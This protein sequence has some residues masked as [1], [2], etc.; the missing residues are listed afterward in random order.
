MILYEIL[1]NFRYRVRS[2]T[3][4]NWRVGHSFGEDEHESES[5]IGSDS[6]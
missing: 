6:E 5:F 2:I 4:L 1:E 3:E